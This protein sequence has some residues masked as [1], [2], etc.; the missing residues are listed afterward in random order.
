MDKIN[1]ELEISKE[2]EHQVLDNHLELQAALRQA[3]EMYKK[4]CSQPASNENNVTKTINSIIS[5]KE[6][7]NNENLI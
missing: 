7:L 4:S 6:N 2:V 5:D 1:I 3:K